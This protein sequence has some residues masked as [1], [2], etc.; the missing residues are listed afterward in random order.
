MIGGDLDRAPAHDE[1]TSPGKAFRERALGDAP[2][3]LEHIDHLF[4]HTSRR[5]WLGILGVTILL[6]AGVLWT[7]V[8]SQTI[9]A[10]A[11]AVIVPRE[12]LFTVPAPIAGVV[13]AVRVG[14]GAVVGSGQELAAVGQGRSAHAAAVLSPIEGTVV[15]VDVRV[16]DPAT[17]GDQMFL[18]APRSAPVVISLYPAAQVSQLAVGQKAQ[19]TVN[20][21]A[22]ARYGMAVGRVVAISP[23]PVNDQRLAQ[24]TGDTSLF[25]LP[26]QLGPLRE[27]DIALAA[28]RTA[29][30]VRWTGGNG[31]PSPLPIGVRAVAVVTVG[32]QTLMQKAFG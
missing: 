19:V 6:A 25:N 26:A 30:G 28:A 17:P 18:I 21:V 5:I 13:D 15:S 11:P 3:P 22:T 16:G 23:I 29:S 31:P 7:A 24:L 2:S 20:G 14:E 4:H 9:T 12:G 8:A 27:I 1:L 10:T 32:R